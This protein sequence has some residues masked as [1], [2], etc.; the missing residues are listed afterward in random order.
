[1]RYHGK[2]ATV[3]ICG[4][5]LQCESWEVRP[6]TRWEN[7]V[8]AVKSFFAPAVRYWAKCRPV[9]AVYLRRY[10]RQLAALALAGGAALQ[11]KY[12]FLPHGVVA[13]ISTVTVALGISAWKKGDPLPPPPELP[14]FD[15][16]EEPPGP[17]NL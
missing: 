8:A 3:E 1:M 15:Q 9:L 7:F 13:F 6:M 10:W 4:I 14:A 16:A 12:E 2:N 17:E 5:K 11:A